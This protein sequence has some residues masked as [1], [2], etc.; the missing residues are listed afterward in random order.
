MY[1]FSKLYCMVRTQSK[2]KSVTNLQLM[3]A[4]LAAFVSGGLAFA[5]AKVNTPRPFVINQ[6][7]DCN[8]AHEADKDIDYLIVTTKQFCEAAKKLQTFRNA[9]GHKVA[10]IGRAHV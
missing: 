5:G 8:T 9:R 2:T 4:L 3:V 1:I 7:Q 10:K 6:E